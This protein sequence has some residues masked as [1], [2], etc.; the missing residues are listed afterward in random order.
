[1]MVWLLNEMAMVS[2]EL[3]NSEK[4]KSCSNAWEESWSTSITCQILTTSGRLSFPRTSTQTH[5][6]KVLENDNE[7]DVTGVDEGQLCEKEKSTRLFPVFLVMVD[8]EVQVNMVPPD[9]LQHV[10][11]KLKN[12][13]RCLGRIDRAAIAYSVIK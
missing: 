1:M 5:H 4:E 13:A 9:G 8:Q 6:K 7:Q 10:F 11:W 2:L 3:A 12:Q